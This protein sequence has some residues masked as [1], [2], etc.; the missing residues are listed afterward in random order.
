[1]WLTQQK[2]G[3]HEKIDPQT[4]KLFSNEVGSGVCKHRTSH[5]YE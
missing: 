1:M 5:A 4:W 2:L 3:E